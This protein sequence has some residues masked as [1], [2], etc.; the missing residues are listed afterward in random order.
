MTDPTEPTPAPSS[1]RSGTAAPPPA[2]PVAP[3]PPGWGPDWSRRSRERRDSGSIFFGV[4]L[5]LIGAYFLLRDTLHIRLPNLGELWP[6][7]LI[8]LG[9]WILVNAARRSDRL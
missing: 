5:L 2:P 7:F 3:T 6:V 9:L 1:S 8:G 4:V